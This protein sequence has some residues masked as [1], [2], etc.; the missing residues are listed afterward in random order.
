MPYIPQFNK[1]SLNE[2]SYAPSLMRKQHDEQVA[3]QMELA[4]ALKFDYLKQDAPGIEP[5]LQKYNAD[6]EDV[7]K[8]IAQQGFSQDLK[9]KVLG[10]RS[11]YVG[12][13][14]IRTYKKNYGDAM[15]QWDETR[16]RLIQ[17]GMPGSDIE[18]QKA[19]FFS[20]YQ[21]AYTPEG[22]KNEF[23]AGRTS[24][25]YDIM[26]DAKKAFAGIGTTGKIVGSTGT[27]VEQKTRTDRF[28]NPLKYFEV[29]D[30]KTG[31][32]LTNLDQRQATAQYLKSEYG[33]ASTD[34][35]LYAKISGIVPEHIEGIVDQVSRS[36]ASDHYSQLP[37]TDT[38]IS[39]LESAG[40]TAPT[41]PW[42]PSQY[43]QVKGIEGAQEKIVDRSNKVALGFDTSGNFN[44]DNIKPD[45]INPFVKSLT[46]TWDLLTDKN[47]TKEMQT[48]TKD[49]AIQL[50]N[51]SKARYK[52]VYDFIKNNKGTDAD[53][54]NFVINSEADETVKKNITYG[55]DDPEALD[56]IFSKV[57][58]RGDIKSF[59]PIDKDG[60]EKPNKAIYR[61][62][63][64]AALKDAKV[65]NNRQITVDKYGDMRFTVKGQ[66][67]KINKEALPEQVKVDPK[68][69]DDMTTA[70]TSYRLTAQQMRSLANK[71]WNIGGYDVR[72]DIDPNKPLA[73]RRLLVKDPTDDLGLKPELEFGDPASVQT[74]ITKQVYKGLSN[75]PK[76]K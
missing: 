36:M 23:T 13:D 53:F 54:H 10:L 61:D 5:V 22:L 29:T 42:S 67:Y 6:I 30:N 39:G 47:K 18:K 72:V 46:G 52:P 41:E 51:K 64:E 49:E 58:E 45:E 32:K 43:Q 26:E 3:N 35:G 24:N 20:G 7:S 38:N 25:Y 70:L 4:E 12:D 62:D 2:M 15:S 8:Q 11:Q 44:P 14:K 40:R 76:T 48:K 31:Q 59:I 66:E 65:S 27:T 60:N 34:R 74:Y 75:K 73:Q 63:L 21:G 71:R 69:I 33:D 1:L 16:K 19:A 57:G 28:G 9:N 56:L 17:T 68:E 37:Q 50:W 55:L